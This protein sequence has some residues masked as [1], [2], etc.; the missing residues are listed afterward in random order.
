MREQA[1]LNAGVRIL[2]ADR[3]PGR[4]AEEFMHYEGGIREF[5]TF[6]NKNKTPLHDSVIYM[7]GAKDDSMAEIAMQ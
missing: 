6:I 3:R 2:M 7:A 5:V 1:F 4:E